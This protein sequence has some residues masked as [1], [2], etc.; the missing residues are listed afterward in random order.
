M[1]FNLLDMLGIVADAGS[2][3][4]ENQRE[5]IGCL[6]GL[7]VTIPVGLILLLVSFI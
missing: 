3:V 7:A 6:L 5:R 4:P 1:P 2:G